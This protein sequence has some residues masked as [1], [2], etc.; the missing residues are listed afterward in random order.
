[1]VIEE[2]V[3]SEE[4]R[5]QEERDPGTEQQSTG[6]PGTPKSQRKEKQVLKRGAVIQEKSSKSAGG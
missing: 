6:A 5:V 4:R 3:T 2:Q 1:M